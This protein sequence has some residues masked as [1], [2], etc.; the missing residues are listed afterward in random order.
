M[1]KT[2]RD[3]PKGTPTSKVWSVTKLGLFLPTTQKAKHQDDETAAEKEFI[4]KVAMQGSKSTSLKF[5][6]P[7]IGTQGYLWDRGK[8]VLNVERGDWR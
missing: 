3:H 1:S 6:S 5:T 4:H 2:H 7:K 8:V